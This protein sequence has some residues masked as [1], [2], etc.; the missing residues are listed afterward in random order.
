MSVCP[1]TRSNYYDYIIKSVGQ[2]QNTSFCLLVTLAFS[3]EHCLQDSY[4]YDEISSILIM[5]T[6]FLISKLYIHNGYVFVCFCL[7]WRRVWTH[8]D[9]RFLYML[10]EYVPGGELFSYLRTVHRF[11]NPTSLFFASEIVMALDYLHSQDMVYR[12]VMAV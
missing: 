8:H 4:V 11:D 2:T 9:N 5:P 12:C 1:L 6:L 7:V 3:H 10:L